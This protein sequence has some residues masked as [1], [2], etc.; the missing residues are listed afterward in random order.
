VSALSLGTDGNTIGE[1]AG[2]STPGTAAA[3][4]MPANPAISGAIAQL[5]VRGVCIIES[6]PLLLIDSKKI[7]QEAWG[8]PDNL[9]TS[10]AAVKGE[11]E[12]SV[13]EIRAVLVRH[14]SQN[15]SFPAA[16]IINHRLAGD[17]KSTKVLKVLGD[18]FANDNQY[19]SWAQV[20]RILLTGD[21]FPNLTPA[22]P[23]ALAQ[24]VFDSWVKKPV[25]DPKE[26]TDAIIRAVIK[27][28]NLA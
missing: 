28:M 17:A 1:G 4:T 3:P 18:N 14:F 10:H 11:I 8:I 9:I 27:R 15:G 20:A 25:F 12:E 21:A 2:A 22:I 16:I 5:N 19:A 23:Q 13:Q 26:L 6:E 7:C 24:N